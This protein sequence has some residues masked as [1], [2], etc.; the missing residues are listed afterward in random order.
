MIFNS[1]SPPP[2][3]SHLRIKGNLQIERCV[4]FV[5]KIPLAL[6]AS[7]VKNVEASEMC[8]RFVDDDSMDRSTTTDGWDRLDR[9]FR[10]HR[11]RKLFNHHRRRLDYRHSQQNRHH[12]LSLTASHRPRSFASLKA[13]PSV[14]PIKDPLM[15]SQV[16]DPAQQQHEGGE[17]MYEDEEEGLIVA[18]LS[19][20]KL[21][22]SI[23]TASKPLFLPDHD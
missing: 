9:T 4:Y 1:S 18:P 11:W 22:V 10:D 20:H 17:G 19:V 2:P 5:V 12:I 15:T 7:R 21:Q 8:V 13:S 23:P 6:S 16:E 3:P 14:L